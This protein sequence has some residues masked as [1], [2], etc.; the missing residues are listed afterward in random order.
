MGAY[1]KEVDKEALKWLG[2]V[3]AL[4]ILCAVFYQLYLIRERHVDIYFGINPTAIDAQNLH[5]SGYEKIPRYVISS[6]REDSIRKIEVYSPTSEK[7][8]DLALALEPGEAHKEITQK[9]G[10]NSSSTMGIALMDDNGKAVTLAQASRLGA[11]YMGLPTVKKV[12][13]TTTL[14]YN[15]FNYVYVRITDKYDVVHQYVELDYTLAQGDNS[16][17]L[18][19]N[20]IVAM[21]G[22]STQGMETNQL[23]NGLLETLNEKY[24]R[25]VGLYAIMV[26]NAPNHYRSIKNVY[27]QDDDTG[28]ILLNETV[29]AQY[30][31]EVQ[32]FVKSHQGQ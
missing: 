18:T 9:S 21:E 3:F 29:K 27:T 12:E 23:L 20:D 25:S 17:I 26:E 2:V 5:Q 13:G 11:F 19:S 15:T 14:C 7:G 1:F 8:V 30:L 22:D 6:N 24:Y 28:T 4:L 10:E 16:S 32:A 31:A